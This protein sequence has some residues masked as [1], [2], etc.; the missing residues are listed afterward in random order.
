MGVSLGGMVFACMHVRVKRIS[1][2]FFR[3]VDESVSAHAC[4]S[5]VV[6]RS[7]CALG[8]PF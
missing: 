3:S 7:I 6:K 8:S 4:V 5:A 2:E 1:R